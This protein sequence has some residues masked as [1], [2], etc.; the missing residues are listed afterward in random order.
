VKKL[1]LNR[2]DVDWREV[3]G[4]VIALRRSTAAYLGVNQAGTLLWRA[5][6][7]G[8][9]EARLADLLVERYG[10]SGDAARADVGAFVDQLR[11]QGLVRP[12]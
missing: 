4:E 1:Q 3:E 12:A 8:A 5:L 11:S 6:Q 9:D 10:I 2:D 7:A